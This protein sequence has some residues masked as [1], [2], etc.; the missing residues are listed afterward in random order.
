[1][2]IYKKYLNLNLTFTFFQR[3]KKIKFFID[4]IKNIFIYID[5]K[6]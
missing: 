4:R 6:S 1:M 5:I 3:L 2:K